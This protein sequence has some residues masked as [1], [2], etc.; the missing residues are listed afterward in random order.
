VLI[1]SQTEISTI[2][3]RLWRFLGNGS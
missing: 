1:Q 2:I 3:T